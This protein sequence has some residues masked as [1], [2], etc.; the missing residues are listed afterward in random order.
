MYSV[1]LQQQ[2]FCE[3]STVLKNLLEGQNFAKQSRSLHFRGWLVFWLVSNE[4]FFSEFCCLPSFSLVPND[5]VW[6]IGLPTPLSLF[7]PNQIK[8]RLSSDSFHFQDSFTPLILC[9]QAS[10]LILGQKGRVVD[11]SSCKKVKK[12]ETTDISTKRDLWK[13][14]PYGNSPFC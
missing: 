3:L 8:V 6:A 7:C 1:S 9:I 13:I 11:F 4:V 12:H 10:Q 2:E 14:I 5:L